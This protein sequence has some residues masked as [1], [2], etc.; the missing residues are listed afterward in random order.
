MDLV[1]FRVAFSYVCLFELAAQ[2][3]STGISKIPQPSV[4]GQVGNILDL[5]HKSLD[6]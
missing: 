2:A 4:T 5:I 1:L 6:V 3:V